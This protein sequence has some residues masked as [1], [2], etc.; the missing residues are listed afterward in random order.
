[1]EIDARYIICL[2]ARERICDSEL[3]HKDI[4]F[5][6]EEVRLLTFGTELQTERLLVGPTVQE[7]DRDQ[8]GLGLVDQ[9]HGPVLLEPAVLATRLA[10]GRLL[11]PQEVAPEKVPMD[12]VHR[13]Q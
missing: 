1:M 7:V 12:L 13:R 9:V 5:S 4:H 10:V 6:V 8:L 3:L 11:D 2:T